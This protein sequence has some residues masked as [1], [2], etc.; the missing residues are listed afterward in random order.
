MLEIF[1]IA[2]TTLAITLYFQARRLT[3]SSRQTRPEQTTSPERQPFLKNL[4]QRRPAQARS[5]H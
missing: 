2:L 1:L 5:D 4:G 3:S